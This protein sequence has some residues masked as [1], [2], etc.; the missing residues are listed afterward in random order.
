MKTITVKAYNATILDLDSNTEYEVLIGV[1]PE[2]TETEAYWDSWLDQKI[3]FNMTIEDLNNA[4][5][6]DRLYEDIQLV[7]INKD[8]YTIMTA[9]YDET[10]Y[11][12]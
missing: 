8:E 6:G 1:V 2:D 10:Q 9:E 7:S 5:A 12:D 11:E 4:K 3:Y